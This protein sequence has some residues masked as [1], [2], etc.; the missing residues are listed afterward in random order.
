MQGPASLMRTVI[1]QVL[2]SNGPENDAEMHFHGP[3]AF[4]MIARPF[5]NLTQ[6]R[7]KQGS[8]LRFA[9]SICLVRVHLIFF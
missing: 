1:G 3:L 4:L 2:R 5:R 7:E 9:K 8:T 6:E